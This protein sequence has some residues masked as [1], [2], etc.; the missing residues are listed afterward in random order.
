MSL[1]LLG[2]ISAAIFV[3]MLIL[4]NFYGLN[5]GITPEAAR[6]GDKQPY[7]SFKQYICGGVGE[8]EDSNYGWN[9]TYIENLNGDN[10]PD[11]VVGTPW[12]DGTFST[13][14]GKIYI[15][16]GSPN[17]GLSDINCSNADVTI[18]GDAEGNKFGWDIA[19][20]GDVNNDGINDLIVGAPGALDN[21]GRVYIFFG[22]NIPSGSFTAME[23]AD[24][25]FD[26]LTA[27][28]YY[29]AAVT[30]VGDINNDGHD[31]VLVGAPRADQAV[32]SYGYKDKIT[33][34]P[35]IWDDNAT[36]K[37]IITFD[38]GVNNTVNDLNTWGLDGD[39]DGWD[40]IDSFHDTTQLYGQTT[41]ASYDHANIYAPWEDDGPD[42]D[43]LTLNN[44]TALE[45]MIGRNHTDYNPYGGSTGYD[46]GASAAW[47]I[48]FNITN[49]MFDYISSNSTITVSFD[50]E[51]TDTNNIYGSPNTTWEISTIRSR[52][53]NSSDN[54]DKYY[55]G[56]DSRYGDKY[57]FYY[58]GSGLPPWGPFYGSFKYDITD[59]IDHAGSFYWDFGCYLDRGFFT[60]N[61]GMMALFDNIGMEITNVKNSILQGISGSGFGSSVAGIGDINEDGLPDM[62][63]GAP[64]LDGGHVAMI[65]GK[66]RFNTIESENIANVIL[67][68]RNNSD[69]FGK[70]VSYAG[71]VDNDNIPDIIIGAPG[72]NYA[73]LYFGKTLNTPAFIPDMWE[74][75]QEQ[76]TPQVE[77]NSA[78]RSTGNTPGISG[79]NDGWDTWDGVYGSTGTA[80][81]STKY[82][83]FDNINTEQI[84]DDDELIISIGGPYGNSARPDSGAYGIEFQIT[85]EMIQAIEAG[86]GAV[87]SYNWDYENKFLYGQ[88]IWIRNYI[89]NNKDNF[90]LGWE[91]DG[92]NEEK[93]VYWSNNPLYHSDNDIFIQDC[94]ECFQNADWFYFDIGGK[95]ET[96]STSDRGAIFH[97]DNIH[98]RINHPPDIKFIGEDNTSFGASVGYC[99]KLNHDDYGDI[100]IGAPC[101]DSP[102]GIDS[103]AIYGFFTRLNN[104]LILANNSEFITFGENPGDNLG[105][106]LLESGV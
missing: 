81:S 18:S 49:E 12:Y 94:S 73:N 90:D 14:V 28:G 99:D 2:K 71:D 1:K 69:K 10:Y 25:S 91:F 68:G 95:V 3:V 31:E 61:C 80:G 7:N 23:Q 92:N 102:N 21:R 87:I 62:V 45:I 97:F 6:A 78:P 67:T 26:G 64:N 20:A 19:D 9:I 79:D 52:I 104:N 39:D 76:E 8:G 85:S 96:W 98:L 35:N 60:S 51:V 30:G 103:G 47:G 36:S 105:W 22:G 48:E 66:K 17:S 72:G 24:R 65:H 32:I 11:L 4:M 89:R 55:I 75:I 56:N 100:V 86:G 13:D 15:F 84:A 59:Y 46:P 70:S 44:R 53:W 16:F 27:D 43:G 93:E 74:N 33:F 58:S 77:F 106:S 29:G 34:Y 57:I 50:Y 63:I 88:K 82:N 38:N 83:G 42:A 41:G 54:A 101:F 5:F 37:G 40:W